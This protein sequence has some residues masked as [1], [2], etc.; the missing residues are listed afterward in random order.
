L[1]HS[2]RKKHFVCLLSF[3][4]LLL[5]GG[6]SLAQGDLSDIASVEIAQVDN[7]A[8]P[9]VTVYVRVLD[10]SGARVDGLTQENFKIT[11]DTKVVEIS[12]FS[13]VNYEP[14]R[15]LLL[16]DKSGSMEAEGKMEGAKTAAYTFIG[17]MRE[18]DQ[19]AIMAFDNG[20][21]LIQDFTSDKTALK[22]QIEPL[23]PGDCTSWYEAVYT[24]ADLTAALSGRKSLILL[25]DGMDCR[26]DW[27]LHD[28]MGYGSYHSFDE[29]LSKMQNTETPVYSIAL[30]LEPAANLGAEGYDEGR[31]TRIAAQTGGEYYHR[32]TADQLVE[33]YQTLARQTQGEYV[34]TY[35]SPRPTY[36]GT[37]RDIQV[38][39]V[40]AGAAG[41]AGENAT[42]ITATGTYV[43]EHLLNIESDWL[44]GA[45][46]LS[47][48]LLAA[49]VPALFGG[50]RRHPF[51]QDEV[52]S[53]CAQCGK[54]MRPGA[55]FCQLCGQPVSD[56]LVGDVTQCPNCGQSAQPGAKF[57]SKCGYRF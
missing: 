37:R 48:L 5:P 16:I 57:C 10:A 20:V 17:Q 13:G 30:G 47:P 42:G 27:W 54:P 21:N 18:Q 34:L 38:T 55:K 14:I 28:V 2:D 45:I 9:Q 40:E 25:S 53:Q 26:E 22:A 31:L 50:L 39:I 43:E 4:L 52:F 23:T 15:T 33:L 49:V 6:N 32:P 46:L 24:A 11:E 29:A 44:V 51:L 35:E 36:D 19:A 3:V 56:A 8:Y 1:K 41:E 7:S 12:A